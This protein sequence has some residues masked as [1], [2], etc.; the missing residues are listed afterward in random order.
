MSVTLWL[1]TEKEETIELGPT[2]AVY[3]SFAEMD[4]VAGNWD[5]EYPDLSGVLVQCEWQEDADPEW[6]AGV[7]KQSLA[8]LAKYG[9]HLSDFTHRL[10]A[11]LAHGEP[12][13]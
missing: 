7:K 1:N 13:P 5:E 12:T 6:L 9:D 8:F 11:M 10:L 2:L 3:Q 4:S